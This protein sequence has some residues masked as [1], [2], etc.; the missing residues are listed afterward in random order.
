M[1]KPL[2]AHRPDQ[3]CKTPNAKTRNKQ[4]NKRTPNLRLLDR[5]AYLV[6]PLRPR[7][8]IVLHIVESEELRENEPGMTRTFANPAVNDRVLSWIEAEVINI[9]LPKSS[10]SG[11][12]A[13]D[14]C[15]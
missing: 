3:L 1:S 8:V 7:P 15:N 10:R 6:A 11:T 5:G 4:A 9:N 12:A 2:G 13:V 14:E